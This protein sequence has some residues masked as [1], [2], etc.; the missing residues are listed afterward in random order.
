MEAA[1]AWECM[2]GKDYPAACLLAARNSRAGIGR[3]DSRSRLS[4]AAVAYATM[5]AAA[6]R[7][8]TVSAG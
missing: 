4:R 1:Y 2:R 3:L 6:R 5:L 8:C 7:A